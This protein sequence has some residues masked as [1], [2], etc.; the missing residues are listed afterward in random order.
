MI[1]L[2]CSSERPDVFIAFFLTSDKS[3]NRSRCFA[4]SVKYVT[5]SSSLASIP[6]CCNRL[7]VIGP[8]Q[9]SYAVGVPIVS[10]ANLSRPA[11]I[12]II[13]WSNVL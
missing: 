4:I 10:Q 5:K 11:P 9:Q 8:K 3:L 12:S 1:L 13:C 2:I 6:T 7:L